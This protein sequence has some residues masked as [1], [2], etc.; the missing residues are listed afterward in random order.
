MNNNNKKETFQVPE[1]TDWFLECTE[2]TLA[3]LPIL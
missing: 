2:Q 1:Y 3:V